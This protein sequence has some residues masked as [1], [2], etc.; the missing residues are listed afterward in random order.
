MGRFRKKSHS[1]KREINHRQVRRVLKRITTT[2][3][4]ELMN[5]NMIQSLLQALEQEH[6]KWAVLLIHS[7]RA[8]WHVGQKNKG[9]GELR[10]LWLIQSDQLWCPYG[11]KWCQEECHKFG[12]RENLRGWKPQW[13]LRLSSANGKTGKTGN[14]GERAKFPNSWFPR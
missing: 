5:L 1:G 4:V 9:A 7:W 11:I 6:R 10:I 8:A 3:W 14:C 2:M 12:G 13:D